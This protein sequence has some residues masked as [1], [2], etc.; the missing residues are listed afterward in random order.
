MPKGSVV[1]CEGLGSFTLAG[2]EHCNR[3]LHGVDAGGQNPNPHMKQLTLSLLPQPTE[4]ERGRKYVQAKRHSYKDALYFKRFFFNHVI[5][6]F[7]FS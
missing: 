1:M 7:F 2:N 3:M 5:L 4:R 6:C